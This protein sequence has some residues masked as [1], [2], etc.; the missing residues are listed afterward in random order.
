MDLYEAHA[1][2][3]D[4]FEIIAFHDGT[5]KDFPELDKKLESIKK[6]VW[7]GKDLPFPILLDSTGET[8]KTYDI[9]AFPTT[10]LIDPEG[11]LVG[12]ADESAL[13]A[14]L[15]KLP[16]A[17]RAARALDRGVTYGFT[18]PKLNEA[19]QTLGAVA[20]IPIKLDDAALK[21]KKIDT[22][23]VV[24]FTMAGRLTLRSFL[25]LVLAADGLTYKPDGDGLLITVG[26]PGEPSAAQKSC[27]EHINNDVL[28]KPLDFDVKDK[29]LAEIAK[30]FE[31]KTN[32][33]FV[34]DPAARRAGKLDANAKLS[35]SSQ[36]A[37]LREGLKKLL[38]PMKL[39][40]VVRD[41]VV[42]IVP[43]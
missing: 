38:D 7:A 20:R 11:K 34:L 36:G 29:T 1:K 39:T 5:V 16:P 18:D 40:F 26:S 28:D 15:P 31:T 4:K 32:E 37:P 35:A 41:E 3:R 27:A 23:A 10:I 17:V 25:N 8:I 30:F 9:H 6:S 13:E 14:K 42:V 21:A 24:P 19:V 12:E 2:E 43:K 22:E 33:N